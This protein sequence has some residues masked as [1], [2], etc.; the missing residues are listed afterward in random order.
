MMIMTRGATLLLLALACCAAFM[1][2]VTH[3]QTIYESELIADIF[4]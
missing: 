4:I 2:G 1:C 3:A